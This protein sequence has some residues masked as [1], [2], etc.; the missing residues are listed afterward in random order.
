MSI[1]QK[2]IKDKSVDS[3]K[4]REYMVKSGKKL[5]LGYTTGSCAAAA[6]KASAI[7]LLEKR[8]V[9]QVKLLLP[10][11]GEL[12]LEIGDIVIND[13]AA[14]C[15]VIKDAG[16]D[17]D[18]TDGIKIYAKVRKTQSN[19]IIDGGVGVGKVTGAG[20]PCKVGEAA[21][22]P[23]PKKMIAT[24]LLEVAQLYGY[25]GGF[26]VEIFVPQGQEIAKKTFNERLGIM[27][28]I[29]ILGT[30]GIVEPM[31]ESSLI[32][33]IKLELGI[34]KQNGQKVSFVAPGNYGLDFAREHLGIDINSAVKCSNYIGE[35]L[36][37]ALYLGFE[38]LL[39]V[40]HIGKL[41][42]IAAGVMNTHSKI[43]DCRNEI[44][45]A[46][47]ALM[48]ANRETVEKV[49]NAKTTNEIHDILTLQS[50][51][52]KVYESILK[53]IIFHLNY[54]VMNK[55]QIEVVV[56]SNEIGVLMQTDNAAILINELKETKL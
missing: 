8:E 1:S 2:D 14:S 13:K 49:M 37:H 40:G 39:L 24:A 21:I 19:I 11:G 50:L 26:E 27:G 31:S 28:G 53:K 43:A 4:Q 9:K 38:K 46:H 55:M 56:F 34:K 17:P 20:L 54:R 42:K 22:N 23:G 44:F 6:A 18:I 25:E 10:N 30:T 7:M 29:S 52:Q 3:E 15:C 41:V 51:S 36:D 33:T 48:G 12:D 35:A 45:A 16:D 5:R 47:C 32:E